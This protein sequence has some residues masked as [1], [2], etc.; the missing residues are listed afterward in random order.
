MPTSDLVRESFVGQLIYHLSGRRFLQYAEDRPDFELPEKYAVLSR[1]GNRTNGANS[2]TA[3]L[4]PESKQDE[5]SKRPESGVSVSTTTPEPIQSNRLTESNMAAQQANPP[6][7]V[8]KGKSNVI[9][10]KTE[11]DNP[12]LVDWYG[13][14]DPEYPRNVRFIVFYKWIF[15]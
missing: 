9:H 5:K 6:T 11:V 13:P 10:R 12:Y 2:E 3:T 7:D 15:F 14:N 4:V 1:N 8:E